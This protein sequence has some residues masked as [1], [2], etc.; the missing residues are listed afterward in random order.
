MALPEQSTLRTNE[1]LTRRQYW[2]TL[3]GELTNERESF[4]PQWRDLSDHILPMRGRFFIQD[5]NKGN[6]R[7]RKI[8]DAT[9]TDSSEILSSGMMGGMSSP[10]REWIRLT[11]PDAGL[12]EEE[13]VKGWLDE[14]TRLMTSVFIR[15][16][17]Y[18]G[19]P[20]L[21]EDAGTFATGC[22]FIEEDFDDVIRATVM[23]IGSYMI[24]QDEKARVNVFL[25]EFRMTVRQ[26]V[27]KF[28][29]FG[30][31]QDDVDWRN[32]SAAVHAAWEA[33]HFEQ[34]VEVVHVIAPNPDHDPARLHA[35]Y[36]KFASVY[37]E[38]GTDPA[39]ANVG[40][41]F[42]RQSGY[43]I[44]PVLAPRWSL[45]A[46]DVYGTS[47]PGMKALGDVR[48][49]QHG[50]K[51][52][53]QAI[54][55]LVFPPMVGPSSMR[56][57]KASILSGDLTFTDEQTGQKGFRPAHEVKPDIAALEGKQAQVRFRIRAAYKVNMFLML[58]EVETKQM[59]A[60]EV[61]AKQQEKMLQMGPVLER[62][63]RD[64]FDPLI[65]TTFHF[66]QRQGMIPEAPESI[67]GTNLRVEYISIMAQAQKLAGV[68]NVERFVDFVGRLAEASQD[69]GVWDKVDRQQLVD[70]YA[71][72]MGMDANLVLS[73]EEV[74]AIRAER[75]AAEAAAREVE[76]AREAA[77]A[78]K[79]LS[80]AKMDED[81]ALT[82]LAGRAAGAREGAA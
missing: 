29:R 36:K 73:D 40:N 33:R 3:R 35:R 69:A 20:M 51:R 1:P 30:P 58:A 46:G 39:D 66:M 24:A 48:Q 13:D 42:L 78:A 26:V 6:R 75:A 53:A 31:K 28:A 50:E 8:I 15:S 32:I 44:F 16:N 64:V 12:A 77:A 63:N 80:G 68:V 37:Y 4:V 21:Y 54:D 57:L 25:R 18:V 65:D 67:Q 27:D 45:T 38:R 56:G 81:N 72:M 34:W 62:F 10:A 74:E 41:R 52:G 60:T 55:K 5:S 9:C 22:M 2:E 7:T 82:R 43:D 19:L 59:T 61:M 49:L 11:I 71:D 70:K 76:L 79:D 23:P 47:S 14:V 17:L